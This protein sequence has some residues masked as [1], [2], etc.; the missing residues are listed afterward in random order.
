MGTLLGVHPIVPPLKFNLMTVGTFIVGCFLVDFPAFQGQ[1][2]QSHLTS[3]QPIELGTLQQ[4]NAT[5]NLGKSHINML[6]NCWWL[7]S[8]TTWDVWNPI[9]N[10]KT[11]YQLVQDFSHQQ[12]LMSCCKQNFLPLTDFPRCFCENLA[13]SQSLFNIYPEHVSSSFY[14]WLFLVPLTGGRWH[15]PSP[16]WQY[17]PLIYHLYIAF[18]GGHMLPTTFYG[19]QKQPLILCHFMDFRWLWKKHLQ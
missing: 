11:T 3:P 18:L 19:N 5:I 9:N 7:K 16:N 1:E 4:K 13:A 6:R 12:N 15:S 14:Q 17:I 8:C 2:K 10:G